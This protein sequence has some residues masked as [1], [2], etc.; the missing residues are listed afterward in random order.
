M[1]KTETDFASPIIA[2]AAQVAKAVSAQAVLAYVGGVDDLKLL[3]ATIKP[4]T[5][6]ILI[7]RDR[8][9]QQRAAETSAT[10]MTVP[11]FDLT[12]M[13]QIKMAT[14]LAFSKQLLKAGDVFVF[15]TGAAGKAIDTIVSMQVGK[16]YELFQSVGQPRLT[17]HI[18]RP[19]F[20]RVLT[21]CLELAHEG[22]EGKPV[23]ALFVVGD[24]RDVLKYCVE[25]RINPF[26]GYTEGER[27]ILDDSMRD[28]VKELAKLDGAFVLK[29]NG[30][31][32]SGGTT[33]RGAVT[34]EALPQGLGARHTAAAAITASTK[35]IAI[36]ISESTGVVRVWR[37]GTMITEI[38][39]GVR[40]A[41]TAATP[42]A[43]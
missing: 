2:A 29:G 40:A 27:N 37:R 22:R 10:V 31:I 32:I 36:T 15:L 19:V 7:A 14:L 28:V 20:E 34:G 35:S 13:G 1:A 23:G 17:E 41:P 30:V 18:R 43:G 4:P 39:K 3:E 38:E 24:Q 9:E 26:R 6:L 33:L 12:R 42:R 11:A 5:E 25:G 21:L 8:H 16:E